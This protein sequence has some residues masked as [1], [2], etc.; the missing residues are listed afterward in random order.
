VAHPQFLRCPLQACTA[1]AT[2]Q[3]FSTGNAAAGSANLACQQ[4]DELKWNVFFAGLLPSVTVALFNMLL[5]YLRPMLASMRLHV[6]SEEEDAVIAPTLFYAKFFNS[7]IVFLLTSAVAGYSDFTAA[8]YSI[9]GVGL[10]NMMWQNTVFSLVGSWLGF[11]LS[12]CWRGESHRLRDGDL[13]LKNTSFT[14]LYS[15][16]LGD[17]FNQAAPIADAT[18][19]FVV[20]Y[21]FAP[22]I[23]IML[24]LGALCLL[25][26]FWTHKVTL[27]R[28]SSRPPFSSNKLVR[29]MLGF[30][31]LAAVL[32]G[33]LAA[34]VYSGV[35][36]LY[37]AAPAAMADTAASAGT[38]SARLLAFRAAVATATRGAAL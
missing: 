24:P 16:L 21:V 32:H 13:Y 10:F 23:P 20:C 2:A 6:S 14:S 7:V 5:T 4:I 11:L 35:G 37:R 3:V 19:L 28:A 1:L 36:D 15:K 30:L 18:L 38:R 8:W 34:W 22:G 9:V 33:V 17:P 29:A 26:H 12:G 27:L 31:P 25:V